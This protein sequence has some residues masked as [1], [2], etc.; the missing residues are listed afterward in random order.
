MTTIWFVDTETGGLDSQVHS[1]LSL[2]LVAWQDGRIVGEDEFKIKEDPIIV[3]PEALAVNQI[4]LRDQSNWWMPLSV[5]R[6]IDITLPRR[7]APNSPLPIIGGHNTPF[8][9]GF[10]RRLY[11]I[12]GCH[13]PFSHRYVDTLPVARFL[14]DAGIIKAKGAGLTALC[15]YFGIKNRARHGALGDAVATA[16][17]YTRLLEVVQGKELSK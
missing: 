12:V 16:E 4:D 7:D 9:V 15:A 2:G 8:D 13:Y 14:M 3:T 17:L 5:V 10:V 1:I 6:E 11:R